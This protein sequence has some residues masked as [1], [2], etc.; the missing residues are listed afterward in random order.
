M[1]VGSKE[2]A[3]NPSAYQRL[4]PEEKELQ[5]QVDVGYQQHLD[6]A[7]DLGDRIDM[8]TSEFRYVGYFTAMRKSIELVWVYPAEAAR[9]G[10]QGE[11]RVEFVI[12]KDGHV[13]R[14][15]VLRSSGYRV[16]DEAIVEA[17]K[18]ASPF[19][20]LPEGFGKDK[21]AV[22]G[23]FRYQLVSYLAGAP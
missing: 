16:L 22:T 15:R 13:S 17:L 3:K 20:P 21:I 5:S 8:N 11:V 9:S 10:M 4:L 23:S 6:E 1:I 2:R 18:L 19:S 12:H 7:I 14:I